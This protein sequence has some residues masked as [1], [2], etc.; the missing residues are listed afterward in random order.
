MG[1][2]SKNMGKSSYVIFF[3][4][5]S[6]LLLTS[7]RSTKTIFLQRTVVAASKPQFQAFTDKD[8]FS[9]TGTYTASNSFC[10]RITRTI[11]Y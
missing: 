6:K 11:I 7:L 1:N 5:I 9:T 4:V 3:L 10:A 8:Q 2:V